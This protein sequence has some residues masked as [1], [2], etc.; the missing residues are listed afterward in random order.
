ML[1]LFGWAM[2][3][4][5]LYGLASIVNAGVIIEGKTVGI[6]EVSSL[7][8]QAENNS[9]VINGNKSLPVAVSREE[10]IEI[11][12]ALRFDD[13]IGV[14]T[15]AN[16]EVILYGKVAENSTIAQ[17]LQAAD[18][19]LRAVVYADNARLK[20]ITLP[21]N[22]RPQNVRNRNDKPSAIYFS[23]DNFVYREQGGVYRPENFKADL[24]L[25]PLGK[26]SD[27]DKLVPDYDALQRGDV[28]VEE[29]QNAEHI[30]KNQHAYLS[31]PVINAAVRIGQ[32]TAFI[33]HLRAGG[34]D[35]AQ[36]EKKLL[37]HNSFALNA[38]QGNEKMASASAIN[39]A[40]KEIERLNKNNI[41]AEHIKEILAIDHQY[42][43]ENGVKMNR[44]TIND[45]SYLQFRRQYLDTVKTVDLQKTP[46]EF[47]QAYLAYI[48]AW[49]KTLDWLSTQKIADTPEDFDAFKNAHTPYRQELSQT[50]RKCKEIA[51]NYTGE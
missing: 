15:K 10:L 38:N 1:K 24:M 13:R 44:N 50:F 2:I 14:A 51:S 47:H 36:L 41:Y 46:D 32:T 7:Q 43:A 29:R 27:D 34:V 33:R 19:L 18:E 45:G 23:L 49:N 5:A 22:Y 8:Y 9:F 21:E 31:L 26:D 17:K 28:L 11:I 6:D 39:A 35:L 48:K 30:R 42:S 4:V 3:S 16:N 12:R 20:N 37:D 25:I 40:Q